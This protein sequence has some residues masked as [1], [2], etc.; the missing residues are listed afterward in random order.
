M[1]P[2][3][4]INKFIERIKDKDY[5]D[6]LNDA[7]R[8]V[9]MAESGT[10][11]VKGAVKK[12]EA[13]AL[14]YAADLKGLIFFLGSGIKPHGVSDRVFFSFEPICKNLVDKKRLKPEVLELFSKQNR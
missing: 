2:P 4:D 1:Y 11:G 10:S 8:E 12:R 7:Q 3:Y 9:Y 6:I 14:E 13:G 5:L